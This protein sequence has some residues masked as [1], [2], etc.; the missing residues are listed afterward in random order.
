MEEPQVIVVD[1]IIGVGKS[2]FLEM[3]AVEL[4][5]R[6]YKNVVIVKEPVDKWKESGLLERF[7]KDPKRWAYHFQTTAFHDRIKANIEAFEKHGKDAIYILERSCF[8][9]TLFMKML[10]ANGLVDDLE[11]DS[12]RS[13]WSL[14]TEIMPYKP[15]IFLYLIAP[16][17]VCLERCEK[18][19]R[20]GEN[21]VTLSYEEDLAAEHDN[22]FEKGFIELSANQTAPVYTIDTTGDFRVSSKTREAHVDFVCSLLKVFN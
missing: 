13:W 10:H 6:G 18:R 17:S 3:L 16:P 1:G 20:Q 8:T 14:W 11:M 22:F 12:Y 21:A 19:Q 9:D 5:R 7:Y 15:T 4:P 2:N